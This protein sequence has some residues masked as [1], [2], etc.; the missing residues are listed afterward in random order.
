MYPCRERPPLAPRRQAGAAPIAAVL[1]ALAGLA[2]CAAATTAA[3]PHH[4]RRHD[5]GDSWARTRDA[6]Q[7]TIRVLYVPAEGFAHRGADGRLTG[8]T[9]EIMRDFADWVRESHRVELQK[10]WVEEADWTAFYGRVRDAAAGVFG[11]GNVTITE[12]RRGE[13]AFSPPYLTNVAVLISHED[14]P[15]LERVEAIASTFEGLRPLAFR[16][17]LHEQRLRGLRDRFAPG[18]ELATADSNQE[19][20]ERVAGGGYFA[21]IDVYNF[22]RA[23]D[24]GEPLRRH[25]VADDPAEDFGIIMPLHT[26]WAPLVDRF[27][28][29]DGGYRQ[30]PR[31]RSLLVD[32][33]GPTVAELLLRQTR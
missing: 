16:G 15:E 23:R 28:Q 24:A 26:D 33:L 9:V 30:S 17:T 14:V 20:L 6:G 5:R 31:Y 1:L 10:E 13:L 12:A 8:V 22:W 19:I 11:L 7:G 2:A 27:F 18:M 29:H 32:H 3:D 25:P 4:D 21:F